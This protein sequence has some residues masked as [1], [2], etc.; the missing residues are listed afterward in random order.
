MALCFCSSTAGPGADGINPWVAIPSSLATSQSRERRWAG[1]KKMLKQLIF[2]SHGCKG[3]PCCRDGLGREGI[4]AAP[5]QGG[6]E[7]TSQWENKDFF[8]VKHH[9]RVAWKHGFRG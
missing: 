5:K 8:L 7:G 3:Q 9:V 4:L 6:T 2:L 1:H